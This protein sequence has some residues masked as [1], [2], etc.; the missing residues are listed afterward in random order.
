M[1]ARHSDREYSICNEATDDDIVVDLW[2]PSLGHAGDRHTQGEA[3]EA[4]IAISPGTR[5][6]LEYT[7]RLDSKDNQEVLE[8]NSSTNPLCMSRAASKLFQAWRKPWKA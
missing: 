3:P 5:V 2:R 4:T 1:H 8:S 6:S 7:L